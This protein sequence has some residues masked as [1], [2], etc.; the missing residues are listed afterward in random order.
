MADYTNR[1]GNSW[2]EFLIVRL[3]S[4]VFLALLA[5]VTVF[6]SIA[7]LTTLWNK[8][9]RPLKSPTMY[10]IIGLGVADFMTGLVVE[11]AFSICYL[12]NDLNTCRAEVMELIQLVM[13]ASFLIILF[14][15]WNQ[16]LAVVRPHLYKQFMTKLRVTVLI[17]GIFLYTTS[18]SILQFSR[19]SKRVLL[20][21][22][23]YLHATFVPF[24]LMLSYISMLVCLR[25]HMHKRKA[26]FFRRNKVV[27]GDSEGSINFLP[28]PYS[29]E[30]VERQFIRMN[31][32][33]TVVLFVCTLPSI[34][35][36]HIALKTTNASHE[37]QTNL[38]IAQKVTDDILFIKFALDPFIFAWNFQQIGRIWR[39]ALSNNS[40]PLVTRRS[41]V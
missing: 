13:N 8:R 20:E 9:K 28:I 17:T 19:I 38:A 41:E 7:L 30:C 2:S 6:A 16:F 18:F 25:R 31:L 10:F 12:N 40:S 32:S 29:V 21:I 26:V 23:I 4:G 11:P 27:K 24:L 15:S 36:M 35:V 34:V 33:L 22:D 5:V 39:A 1:T 37:Y 14:L 3:A